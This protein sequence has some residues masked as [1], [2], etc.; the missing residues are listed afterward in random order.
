V[1]MQSFSGGEF[2][3][4]TYTPALAYTPVLPR[5]QHRLARCPRTARARCARRS[6]STGALAL[7]ASD[8]FYHEMLVHDPAADP[9]SYRQVPVSVKETSTVASLRLPDGAAQ[10]EGRPRQDHIAGAGINFG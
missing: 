10:A 4:L 1:A 8:K 9:G 2:R 5:L 6:T 7:I 3:Y